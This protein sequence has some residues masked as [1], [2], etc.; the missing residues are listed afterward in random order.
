MGTAGSRLVVAALFAALVLASCG[1]PS[2]V[3]GT[4]KA[5][6]QK[7]TTAAGPPSAL[8]VSPEAVSQALV[9]AWA[10][11]DRSTIDQLAT[12]T[13]R[14]E[15]SK[16]SFPQPSPKFVNCRADP[17]AAGGQACL[18]EVGAQQLSFT[19]QNK[20]GTGW[21]VTDARFGA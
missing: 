7:K 16:R 6:P 11:N 21:V 12:A 20:P 13:A 3:A 18:F 2:P 9:A 4:D 5:K 10:N 1:A 17:Q 19:T 8:V 14:D 15:I